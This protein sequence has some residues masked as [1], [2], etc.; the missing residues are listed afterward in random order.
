[1]NYKETLEYISSINWKGSVLGLSRI[2]DLLEKLGNPQKDLKFIHIGGTNGKG[3]TAAFLSSILKEAGYKTGLFTS[4]YIETFNERMQ[5]NNENISDEE[6]AEITT[7]IRPFADSMEDAPT[8]FELNTAICMVYFKRNNC[9]IVVLEVGM[10]GELDSTNV[11]D[12]PEAAVITAIGLDHTEE[13]GDT[14]EKIAKT[15]SGI[16]KPG[17]S[18]VLYRQAE[19]VMEVIREKCR[20]TGVELF[21]SEPQ[22]VNPLSMDI[23]GQT[24]SYPGYGKL[25]IPLIG[26][27]QLNNV[28]L[29]LKTVE[30]MQKRGWNIS[31]EAVETGLKKTK[32]PGRFEVILREPLMIVD[33]AHNPHGIRATSESLRTVFPEKKLVFLFGVM[34]DKDYPDM[35]DQIL[36]MAK[37]VCC[38]TPDNPRALPAKDLAKV[39]EE[40]GVKATPYDTIGE[41]VES[42]IQKAKDAK[43]SAV[44]LGSLYMIGDIKTYIKN[45]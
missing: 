25:R 41:A 30:A 26:T 28:S 1:M 13:L 43:T 21:V 17:C 10:G 23:E 19:S 29:A 32:W 16:I 27:Y 45:R 36:P 35:L 7:W 9:D 39:I 18:A 33:G 2:R 5:I 4:P 22:N 42:V 12:S 34:A 24:F 11:I 14:I 6:L 31:K 20:E 15:K 38:V 3:S 40:S 8:E 44:A 37:E